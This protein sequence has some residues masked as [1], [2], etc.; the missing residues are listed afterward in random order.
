MRKGCS[1]TVFC[2]QP[3]IAPEMSGMN[4]FCKMNYFT[5]IAHTPD[6]KQ[7]VFQSGNFEEI[8][9]LLK[10]AYSLRII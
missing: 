8:V 4:K 7:Y 1:A 10:G 9:S 5:C 6:K 3:E 2:K